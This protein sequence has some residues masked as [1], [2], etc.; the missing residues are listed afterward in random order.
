MSNKIYKKLDNYLIFYVVN[1]GEYIYALPEDRKVQV[2]K[3]SRVVITEHAP[4]KADFNPYLDNGYHEW[5]QR[6][7]DIE[8]VSGAKLRAIWKRQEGLRFQCGRPMLADHNLTL[9]T[10]KFD[11]DMNKERYAYVHRQ[12]AFSAHEVEVAPQKT[13]ALDLISMLNTVQGGGTGFS[14]PIPCTSHHRACS[15]LSP[16]R[17][18]PCR[19]HHDKSGAAGAAPL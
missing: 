16:V 13:D 14:G 6:Q 4:I 11:L 17:F 12:C 5:M 2:I 9:I 8:K 15:G 10:I 1:E 3:L 18:R 19:A 7:R